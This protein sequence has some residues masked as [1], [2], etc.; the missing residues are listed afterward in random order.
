MRV[1]ATG[2]TRRINEPRRPGPGYYIMYFVARQTRRP[3]AVVTEDLDV[4]YS[5]VLLL[6]LLKVIE[7]II[8]V[9]PRNAQQSRRIA[10]KWVVLDSHPRRYIH[11]CVALACDRIQN[12]MNWDA[13]PETV[14]SRQRVVRCR[15]RIIVLCIL[16]INAPFVK[17]PRFAMPIKSSDH[18]FV[19][20][21]E[22]ICLTH[23]TS[24]ISSTRN[25]A[26]HYKLE[27]VN[28]FIHKGRGGIKGGCRLC[29]P[30]SFF[31]L[32]V[33]SKF[34]ISIYDHK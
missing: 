20:P 1:P 25:S 23:D 15:H 3:M 33:N 12:T 8:V 34:P 18:T 28:N 4:S 9:S 6:L 13:L 30:Y 7:F 27:T 14:R 5:A 31:Y 2:R 19:M 21:G 10:I 11:V 16:A 22:R 29:L 17:I 24:V 26:S 32:G